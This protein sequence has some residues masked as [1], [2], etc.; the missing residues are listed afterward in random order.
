MENFPQS[1][2]RFFKHLLSDLNR[3]REYLRAYLPEELL[4]E[5]D[6]GTLK[7]ENGSFIDDALRESY[8]DLVFSVATRSGKRV[9]PCFLVEHKSHRDETAVFQALYYASSAMLRRARNGEEQWLVIPILFYHGEEAWEYRP[10]SS[11]FEGLGEPFRRYLPSFD[12]LYHNFN[13]LPDAEIASLPNRLLASALLVMKHYYDSGYL[14]ENASLLLLGAHD[15]RGNFYLPLFVYFFSK[16]EAGEERVKEIL[17]S[18][19]PPVKSSVMSI[20]D[21]YEAK[22]LEKGL[23]QGLEQGLEKGLEKGLE[24]GLEKGL[25]QGLEKGK[26]ETKRHACANMIR[27]GFDV[28][29]VCKVLEVTPE[30]VEEVRRAVEEEGTAGE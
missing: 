6:L 17:D 21:I 1:H 4:A 10:L 23:E 18:L 7:L 12:Y 14:E 30:F 19:P 13:A 24:Q 26:T 25:E 8:S 29:A 15:E 3:A 16:I 22:G 11:F 27:L 2:D 28:E 9:N 20:F 5:L